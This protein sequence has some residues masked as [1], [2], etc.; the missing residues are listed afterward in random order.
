MKIIQAKYYTYILFLLDISHIL[1]KLLKNTSIKLK[2]YSLL[3][4]KVYTNER[5]LY[6]GK[7]LRTL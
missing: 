6:N 2:K 5:K 1:Y 7:D 4:T 3:R